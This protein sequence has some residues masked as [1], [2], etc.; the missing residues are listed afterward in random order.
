MSS[1]LRLG[2]CPAEPDARTVRQ[3]GKCPSGSQ[4]PHQQPPKQIS[5][6]THSVNPVL[7]A[8]LLVHVLDASRSLRLARIDRVRNPIVS[9]E[10]VLWAFPTTNSAFES[11][12]RGAAWPL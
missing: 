5:L 1:G 12:H 7:V 8:V 3:L 6:S 2:A 10:G 4:T 9:D 11:I